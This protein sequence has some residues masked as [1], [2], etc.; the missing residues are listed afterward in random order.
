M[1]TQDIIAQRDLLIRMFDTANANGNLAKGDLSWGWSEF[2]R[3]TA[4]IS[5]HTTS[6][7]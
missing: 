6:K 4:L 5:K 3:L 7:K 2:Q 1:L